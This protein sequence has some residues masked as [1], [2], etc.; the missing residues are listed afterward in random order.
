MV[1][2]F[3]LCD[4]TVYLSFLYVKNSIGRVA[5]SKYRLLFGKRFDLSAAVDG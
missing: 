1:A 4:T 3:P 2:S 5:L